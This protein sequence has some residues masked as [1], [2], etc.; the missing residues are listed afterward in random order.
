MTPSA[1]PFLTQLRDASLLRGASYI[2]GHWSLPVNRNGLRVRDPSSGSVIARV[3]LADSA[4]SARAVDAAQAGFVIW[5]RTSPEVRAAKLDAWGGAIEQ[6]RDDLAAI[7]VA[8]QGKPF[9]EAVGEIDYA[10][11]FVRYYAQAARL[12][13]VEDGPTHF[14]DAR[15]QILHEPTG[16]AALITPWNFP[17]AMITRKAAAAMAAG[18]AVLVSPSPETPL[19]ALA[20]AALAERAGLPAGV[21]NVVAGD[22]RT[23]VK[24]WLADAR[25]RVLSFTGST[26]VGQLLYQRSAASTKRLVLEL[27][28]HAPFIVCAD[29]DLAH[30]VT[31]AV[32]AKFATSGQD[33]LAANQFLIARPLYAAFCQAF[34]ERVQA[35]SIGPGRNNP[36]IGPLING[37][38]VRRQEDHVADALGRGA[39]LLC[40]GARHPAGPN[41]FMPTVLADVP[42]EALLFKEETFGPIAGMACFDDVEDAIARANATP[43]GL[44]AYVHTNSAATAARIEQELDCGMIAVNRTRMTGPG[45]PFG[46][47]KNSGLGR[48]GG[49]AGLRAFQE[50]KYVCRQMQRSEEPVHAGQ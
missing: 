46:G 38:A 29:A 45:V 24:P 25:V 42:A 32:A 20:L 44:A 28:G 5:R 3:A 23:I 1:I 2:G 48:E 37:R 43:Y 34:A 17:S 11:S 49:I 21:F 4:G 16:I 50:T 33:C 8:E 6:A 9:R 39:R 30:A 15:T 18:C 47:W 40:G 26:A 14:A 12:P 10:L 41:F 31:M 36:D 22:P 27:G 35:L 13:Q 19:S 7:L